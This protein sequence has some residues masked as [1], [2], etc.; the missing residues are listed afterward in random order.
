MTPH[1]KKTKAGQLLSTFIRVIMEEETEFIKDENGND[2]MATKAEALARMIVKK[3][4]GYSE[5]VIDRDGVEV[6]IAHAPDK[7]YVAIVFDR[8]EGRVPQSLAEGEGKLTAAERV[9]EQG[10][11]R[12]NSVRDKSAGNND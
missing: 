4:L 1:G 2:R 5:K 12:I 11:N 6:E 10:V 7:T 3:A 9:T 8:M